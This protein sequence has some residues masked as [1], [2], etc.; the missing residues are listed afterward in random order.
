MS[1]ELHSLQTMADHYL[2]EI[3]AQFGERVDPEILNTIKC[4]ERVMKKII[5]IQDSK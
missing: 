4:F 1:V 3:S 5:E 2:I